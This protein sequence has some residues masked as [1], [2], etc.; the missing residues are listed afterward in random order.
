MEYLPAG[1]LWQQNK[2]A[3]TIHN[4]SFLQITATHTLVQITTRP[5]VC[6]SF[7]TFIVRTM[8]FYQKYNQH[9]LCCSSQQTPSFVFWPQTTLAQLS[10]RPLSN[11]I[12]LAAYGYSP[13]VV[14][15]FDYLFFQ[16]ILV[17]ATFKT[18]YY[19]NN[20]ANQQCNGKTV[21]CPRFSPHLPHWSGFL[22][23][24]YQVG[25][26]IHSHVV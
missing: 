11:H 25:R 8:K 3:S 12:S 9:L 16:R 2:A 6:P 7:L 14:D 26:Y 5:S 4:K 19:P 23:N 21:E 13:R 20:T 17:L 24:R 10:V 1:F 18:K 22:G 15:F